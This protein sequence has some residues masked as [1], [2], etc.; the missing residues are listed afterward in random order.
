VQG[1]HQP[2]D[3]ATLDYKSTVKDCYHPHHDDHTLLLLSPEADIRYTI[4]L[5][6][7][8]AANARGESQWLSW[9]TQLPAV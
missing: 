2:S 6:Q 8:C 9:S 4:P 7:T 3:Q 5:H 1:G